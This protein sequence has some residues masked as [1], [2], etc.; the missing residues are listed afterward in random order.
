MK[1]LLYLFFISLLTHVTVA[2]SQPNFTLGFSDSIKST[3][4]NE[5]RQLLIYTPYNTKI[6]SSTK[7]TYPVLYVLDG[8]IILGY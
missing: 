1:H 8:E 5:Q 6:K 3:I 7:E 2:Q 4:L